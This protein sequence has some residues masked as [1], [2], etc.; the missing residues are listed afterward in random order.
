MIGAGH[1]VVIIAEIGINHEGDVATCAR[2][3]E[4][5]AASGADA[6]KLQTTDADE[7]Y[8]PDT[9]SYATFKSAELTRDETAKMFDL[10]GSLNVEVFSTA[11]DLT[12]FDYIESLSPAAYKISSG[13]MSH[14]P[15]LSRAARTGRTVIMSTGIGNQHEI[16]ESV[17]YVR[18][19]GCQSLVLLQCTSIYPA[20]D[21]ALNLAAISALR[22]TFATPVGFSDHSV[23]T[24]AS[25]LSVAAGAVVIEKHFSFDTGRDGFDHKLSVDAPGLAQLVADVRKAE[26]VM[27]DSSRPASEEQRQNK[28]W[29][30]RFVVARIPV[31]QGDMLTESNLGVMRL[32]PDA[33]GMPPKYFDEFVGR[34]ILR[35]VGQFEPIRP[36]YLE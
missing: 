9:T 34:R 31:N 24:F 33:D 25:A 23:G 32:P 14:T 28:G 26:L 20:P 13:L 12:S 10:A 3:I 22:D 4:E 8:H 11:G 35:D 18:A 19:A 5:A 30:Q 15:M 27:G 29:M 16:E 17:E 36:E 2:L 7:A 21:E 6:V 1:P